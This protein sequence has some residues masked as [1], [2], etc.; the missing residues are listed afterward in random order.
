MYDEGSYDMRYTH[1]SVQF[2]GPDHGLSALPHVLE[3]QI[4]IP[5][6]SEPASEDDILFTNPSI[7]SPL[8]YLSD[9]LEPEA[10]TPFLKDPFSP[11][12]VPSNDPLDLLFGI[13]TSVHRKETAF[14]SDDF[15]STTHSLGSDIS[16]GIA[17]LH[18]D[19]SDST[20]LPLSS[21]SELSGAL[22]ANLFRQGPSGP[23][24]L[25]HFRSVEYSSHGWH[26][27]EEQH[28]G[29]IN[30]NIPFLSEAVD[31]LVPS[32]QNAPS[33]HH[34]ETA[35][36]GHDYCS[37]A[38]NAY[39]GSVV[40]E[41]ITTL[42]L[43]SGVL[44]TD[45]SSCQ[46]PSCPGWLPEFGCVITHSPRSYTSV[47]NAIHI[48]GAPQVQSGSHGWH[49]GQEQH[50]VDTGNNLLLS[51]PT[52]RS[53][54]DRYDLQQ[55]VVH[56][57]IWAHGH[58]PHSNTLGLLPVPTTSQDGH[59]LGPPQLDPLPSQGGRQGAHRLGGIVNRTPSTTRSLTY[60]LHHSSPYPNMQA[61]PYGHS[62]ETT[63]HKCGWRA[64][65]GSTC[66]GSITG[67]TIPEH[68]V[69]HGITD[70]A[71][72]VRI[73]CRWCPDGKKPIKRESIVRHVREVH[74]LL[75]RPSTSTI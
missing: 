7:A 15:P 18:Y 31:P 12:E 48:Q 27:N 61:G 34:E 65:D 19:P 1:P 70:M 73:Q 43:S 40:T 72:S 20:A 11:Q 54:A 45:S 8:S 9:L 21:Y 26:V 30:N 28:A 36:P 53:P 75:K 22:G 56:A 14:P 17:A 3:E 25:Q 51:A 32:F 10:N 55:P 64:T 71:Y 13:T 16:E 38:S 24:S 66:K 57:T 2:H 42:W 59:G 60:P 74:M 44:G 37:T 47:T 62:S 49:V 4:T 52:S 50:V 58:T 67:V 69:Q 33:D 35:L 63:P 46:D 39:S 5:P 23:E 41:G 68:L 6:T 29:D